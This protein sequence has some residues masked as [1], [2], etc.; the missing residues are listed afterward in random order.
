MQQKTAVSQPKE[1]RRFC[2]RPVFISGHLLLAQTLSSMGLVGP[3]DIERQ[4]LQAYWHV[5]ATGGC[6][7]AKDHPISRNSEI[8]ALGELPDDI[9]GPHCRTR[10]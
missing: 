8:R 4:A 5:H 7:V 2:I 10:A 1:K 6:S 3:A 9:P